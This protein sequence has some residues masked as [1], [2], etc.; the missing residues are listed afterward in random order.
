MPIILA[1]LRT[2][3]HLGICGPGL[4]QFL[5]NL[6][7]QN[8]QTMFGFSLDENTPWPQSSAPVTQ[9]AANYR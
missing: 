9:Q 4:L 8:A 1:K 7:D 5:W 3:K 6:A 2:A